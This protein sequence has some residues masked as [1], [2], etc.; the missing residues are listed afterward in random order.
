MQDSV[1]APLTHTRF[2][3][4][5]PQL[6]EA[7]SLCAEAGKQGP[8]DHKSA[9]LVKLAIAI[10]TGSEGAV[11]SNVRKAVADGISRAEIMQTVALCAGTVGFPALAAGFA[12]VNSALEGDHG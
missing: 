11:R 10:A 1:S 9:R 2:V 3:Q 7:W 12:W 6:A 5:F 8:L 4:E